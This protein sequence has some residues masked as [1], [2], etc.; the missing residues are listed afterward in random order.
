MFIGY[1]ISFALSIKN[2]NIFGENG[3]LEITEKYYGKEQNS[4]YG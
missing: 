3:L 2:S 4:N 1:N